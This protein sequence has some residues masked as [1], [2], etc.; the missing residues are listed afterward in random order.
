VAGQSDVER[1]KRLRAAR[2]ARGWSQEKLAE[3]AGKS[4]KT[5]SR[6]EGGKYGGNLGTWESI[7]EVLDLEGGARTPAGRRERTLAWAARIERLDAT[8]QE[9]VGRY[10]ALLEKNTR[11]AEKA[12][13]KG[14]KKR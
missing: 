5:I 2:E 6:L 13:S 11:A 8:S 7:R 3:A 12:K 10:I 9:M 14:K 4:A 1:G